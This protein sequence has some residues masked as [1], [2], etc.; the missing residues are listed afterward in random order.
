MQSQGGDRKTINLPDG[1]VDPA[2]T[3]EELGLTYKQIFEAR[4]VRD[5]EEAEPGIVRRTLDALVDA[6][7]EPTR[8]AVTAVLVNR[9]HVAKGK[10]A[11][12]RLN[13]PGGRGNRAKC[14][15]AIMQSGLSENDV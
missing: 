5:A 2:A 8:A 3:T 1:K 9:P 4:Q 12:L 13:A 7:A 11:S 10:R 14:A 15:P 6:G